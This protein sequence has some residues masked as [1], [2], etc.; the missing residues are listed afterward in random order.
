MNFGDTKKIELVDVIIWKKGFGMGKRSRRT[1]EPLIILQNIPKTTKNWT[2]KGIPD[3]FEE[4]IINPRKGHP[5]RKPL[6]FTQRLLESITSP[7]GYVLDPCSGSF[8]TFAVTQ[9]INRNFIGCDL[10]LEYI[11]K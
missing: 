2:D 11:E 8:S 6:L 7:N 3:N 9:K 5:H 4:K 1:F 10:T